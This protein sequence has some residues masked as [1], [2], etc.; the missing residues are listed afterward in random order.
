MPYS[1]IN[2]FTKR[3]RPASDYQSDTSAAVGTPASP[4]TEDDGCVSSYSSVCGFVLPG[5]RTVVLI[6]RVD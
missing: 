2:E 1:K 5:S 6:Q 4:R 3:T